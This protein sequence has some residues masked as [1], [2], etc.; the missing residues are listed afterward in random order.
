MRVKK[1]IGSS[2]TNKGKTTELTEHK[3]E[4]DLT[5]KCHIIDVVPIGAVR[6]T[7]SDRWKTN[8]NHSD[9][10]KRQRPAV[11]RYFF[12]KNKVVSEC[13]KVK[14]EIKNSIDVVFFIPMPDSWSSKKKEKMNGMPH[15]SRPDIDNIVKGFMDALKDQDGDVWWIKAEKRYAYKGSILIYE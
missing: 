14:Y 3:F 13:N 2:G 6:M 9:V 12:F 8:P 11:T 15:K 7:K 5:R 4:V 1:S 10:K